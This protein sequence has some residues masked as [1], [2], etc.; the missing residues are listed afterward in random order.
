MP[1]SKGGTVV[2]KVLLVEDDPEMLDVTAYVLRRERFVVVEASDGAQ[3]LRRWKAD[4]ADLVIL[5][6][7]L[8][9]VDGFAVLR[10]ILADDAR[11]PVLV[12]TGRRDAQNVLR[13]FKLGTDV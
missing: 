9:S 2:I 5:D 1:R 12:I 6:L 8:P 3:A 4:R 10:Q 7:G 11:T 13:S